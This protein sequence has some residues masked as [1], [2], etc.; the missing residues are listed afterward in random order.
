M[1]R[2]MA[3]CAPC[4]VTS[5]V[6]ACHRMRHQ[7]ALPPPPQ[8]PPSPLACAAPRAA[9]AKAGSPETDVDLIQAKVPS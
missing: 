3:L 8:P 9:C 5:V 7:L 4:G 6:R 2:T 1:T